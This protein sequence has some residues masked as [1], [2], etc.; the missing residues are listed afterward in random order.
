MPDSAS[1]PTVAAS[2]S[3]PSAPT[4]PRAL[5]KLPS[6][7]HPAT[8]DFVS[9]QR[10]AHPSPQPIPVVQQVAAKIPPASGPASKISEIAAASAQ[11]STL[12]L[13]SAPQTL[14]SPSHNSAIA[15]HA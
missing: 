5:S 6:T 10:S 1:S 2:T 8:P 14:R 12:A 15:S 7:A 13:T 3:Y 11:A 4:P 9:L